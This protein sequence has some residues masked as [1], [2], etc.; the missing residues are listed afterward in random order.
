MFIC[1]KCEKSTIVRD[2]VYNPKERECY[3]K[4]ECIEC[5]KTYYTVEFDINSSQKEFI[6]AWRRYHRVSRKEKP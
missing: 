3:R 4:V 5:G 6:S 2:S 1:P